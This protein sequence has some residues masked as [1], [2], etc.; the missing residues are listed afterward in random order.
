MKGTFPF[1]VDFFS[2]VPLGLKD[3]LVIAMCILNEDV[4]VKGEKKSLYSAVS[5]LRFI[6][7]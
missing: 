3:Y 4:T 2:V 5:F 1:P 7:K 6:K